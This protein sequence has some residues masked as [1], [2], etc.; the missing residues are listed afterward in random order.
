MRGDSETVCS[1]A[2]KY[3][4]LQRVLDMPGHRGG[5]TRCPVDATGSIG[6]SLGNHMPRERQF[7][8]MLWQVLE[9]PP[10]AVILLPYSVIGMTVS[11]MTV[12]NMSYLCCT[13]S[14]ALGVNG[15]FG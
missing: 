10:L 15:S 3:K 5:L 2:G 11:N 14:Y 12:S 13:T 6:T 1:V 9:A 7:D 4:E 8:P